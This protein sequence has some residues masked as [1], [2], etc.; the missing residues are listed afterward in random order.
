MRKNVKHFFYTQK[1]PSLSEKKNKKIAR[2]SVKEMPI[3]QSLY[4]LELWPVNICMQRRYQTT[5]QK[6]KA[7]ILMNND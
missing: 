2:P 3:F 5:R 6:I 7:D 4:E 1:I